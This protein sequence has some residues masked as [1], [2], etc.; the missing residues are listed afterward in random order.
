MPPRLVALL[1]LLF[2]FSRSW[3]AEPPPRVVASIG[4]VHSLTAA[5]MQGVAEPRLLLPSGASPHTYSLLP[6]DARALHSADLVIWVGPA[7][8]SFLGKAL[9]ELASDARVLQ[10]TE[11]ESLSLLEPRGLDEW[12]HGHAEEDHAPAEAVEPHLWLDPLNAV[13]IGAAVADALAVLDSARADTYRRNAAQLRQRLLALH[14]KIEAAVAPVRERP[15]IVFHDAYHYFEHR[16]GLRAAG[17]ITVSPDQRPGPRRLA[18]I[19]ARIGTLG[20]RCVFREPQF[21]PGLVRTVVEG[22]GARIGTLDPEGADID[23]GPEAYFKLM[24]SLTEELVSC[25]S[26]S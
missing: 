9:Q 24:N 2:A 21:E 13:R 14:Q 11:L 20:A 15:F 1:V 19:R 16:Y 6:S 3:A 5:V 26:A 8:E 25:L 12:T 18:E 23:P 10:L 4:P 7:L 22:T 17:A